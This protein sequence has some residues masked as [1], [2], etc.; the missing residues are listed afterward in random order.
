MDLTEYDR[1]VHT[2]RL[3]NGRLEHQRYT[4]ECWVQDY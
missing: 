1:V 2:A 3:T 4:L